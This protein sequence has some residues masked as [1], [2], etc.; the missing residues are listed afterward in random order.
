MLVTVVLVG[1]GVGLR[2]AADQ[3][4]RR[5]CLL[6]ISFLFLLV[7]S[8]VTIPI[9]RD[10]SWRLSK[11]LTIETRSAAAM[12]ARGLDPILWKMTMLITSEQMSR[13]DALLMKTGAV[14]T[15]NPAR[16]LPT[17]GANC[18]G[19]T[20]ANPR[21]EYPGMIERKKLARW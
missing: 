7:A 21:V 8:R 9:V 16:V 13:L 20:S 19:I 14:G 4:D 1:V 15:V 17:D 11:I 3:I 18:R 2:V 6:L 12:H 5:R 10:R